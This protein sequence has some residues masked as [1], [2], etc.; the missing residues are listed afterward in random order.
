[1]T[2][3]EFLETNNL[4][5]TELTQVMY[6]M[7]LYEKQKEGENGEKEKTEQETVH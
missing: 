5:D 7:L 6:D 2:Y 4:V 3:Q 1:M